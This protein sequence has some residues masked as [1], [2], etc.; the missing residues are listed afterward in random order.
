MPESDLGAL[1]APRPRLPDALALQP[2]GTI[3]D[4]P[5]VLRFGRT[6][7][8]ALPWAELAQ[9]AEAL[10]EG[11][12]ERAEAEARAAI[13]SHLEDAWAVTTRGGKPSRSDIDRLFADGMIMNATYTARHPKPA[14]G[15]LTQDQKDDNKVRSARSYDPFWESVPGDEAPTWKRLHE[16]VFVRD[17]V[18]RVYQL[19]A[20]TEL[21]HRDFYYDYA[22]AWAAVEGLAIVAQHPAGED[23][24]TPAVEPPIVDT[25]TRRETIDLRGRFI[26]A[27]GLELLAMEELARKLSDKAAEAVDAN[28][29]AVV[30]DREA[31]AELQAR[32]LNARMGLHR[33]QRE[34]DELRRR[35]ADM[36]YGLTMAPTSSGAEASCTLTRI[37]VETVT[38][39]PTQTVTSYTGWWPFRRAVRRNVRLPPQT[40]KVTR[41]QPVDTTK[42]VLGQRVADLRTGTDESLGRVAFDVHVFELT[43]GGYRSAEDES[44]ELVMLRCRSDEELRLRTVV[45][46]PTYER[47]LTGERAVVSYTLFIRPMAGMTPIAFPELAV[48]EELSYK[49]VWKQ[50]ELGE[51][52]SSINLAPGEKRTVTVNRRYDRDTTASST[53]TSVFD[54]SSSESTDLSTEMERTARNESDITTKFGA[55]ASTSTTAKAQAEGSWGPVKASGSVESSL[56]ASA[57]YN[58]DRS[59]KDVGTEMAKTARQAAAT[60]NRNRR[61]EVSTSATSTTTVHTSDTS[62]SVIENINQGRTLNLLFHRLYNRYTGHLYL[63]RLQLRVRPGVE[64]IAGSGIRPDYTFDLDQLDPALKALSNVPLPVPRSDEARWTFRLAVLQAVADHALGEYLNLKTPDGRPVVTFAPPVDGRGR[65]ESDERDSGQAGR[66]AGP[67]DSSGSDGPTAG[68]GAG[69]EAAA[70]LPPPL[71]A[72]VETVSSP[73]TTGHTEQGASLKSGRRRPLSA[74]AKKDLARLLSQSEAE[75][76]AHYRRRLADLT[77]DLGALRLTGRSIHHSDLLVAA[78]GLYLDSLVGLQPGTEPYSEAMRT[79]EINRRRAEVARIWSEAARDRAVA[80]RLVS[81]NGS[82]A[83]VTDGLRINE[84]A[85]IVEW[86]P[87]DEGHELLLALDRPLHPGL[88]DLSHDGTTVGRLVTT[89]DEPSHGRCRFDGSLPDWATG[90]KPVDLT[91]TQAATGYT[92]DLLAL[93]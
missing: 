45:A 77:A 78:T 42:D 90:A 44:L 31:T 64:L 15:E 40:K 9:L 87:V 41:D 59:I 71:T 66:R 19:L 27:R 11:S 72:L 35:A 8:I 62:T 33:V 56:S 17:D 58:R 76:E 93:P 49:T 24:E 22:T 1:T 80:A 4:A 6:R 65:A 12:Q 54:L 70:A 21:S 52:V 29:E 5:A 38:W 79:E 28:L 39:T 30:F 92:V 46:L 50:A 26:E 18:G 51:L 14:E 63:D 53:S 23:G 74:T 69:I 89:S 67:S 86:H 13:R 2:P 7:P 32:Y 48:V 37:V 75:A 85:V 81:A 55:E 43:P 36:G 47:S 20:T 68:G 57:S 60:V 16:G 10:G 88:W 83:A 91:V 34:K 73:S 84:S 25:T 61:E 3:E 82:S